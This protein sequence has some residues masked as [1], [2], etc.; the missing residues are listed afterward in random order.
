[1]LEG[2]GDG[3]VDALAIRAIPKSLELSQKGILAEVRGSRDPGSTR[4]INAPAGALHMPDPSHAPVR[5]AR[6]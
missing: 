3:M 2:R 4:P 6:A 1:M 5:F